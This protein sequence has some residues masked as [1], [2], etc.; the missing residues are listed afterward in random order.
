MRAIIQVIYMLYLCTYYVM[1]YSCILMVNYMRTEEK[2]KEKKVE[3]VAGLS[4][5][6]LS[7]VAS[8]DDDNIGFLKPDEVVE[9]EVTSSNEVEEE[10][11]ETLNIYDFEGTGEQLR[12]LRAYNPIVSDETDDEYESRILNMA[13]KEDAEE[14]KRREERNQVLSK[15]ESANEVVVRPRQ[16]KYI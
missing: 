14:E 13:Y 15:V 10:D 8:L 2:E 7:D 16:K 5:A 3:D 11:M 6:S 4:V 1:I 9:E 12:R